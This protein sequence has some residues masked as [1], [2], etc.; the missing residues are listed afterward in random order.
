M[1]YEVVQLRWDQY[2]MVTDIP[3]ELLANTRARFYT[4]DNA[5]DMYG[6]RIQSDI[7]CDDLEPEVVEAVKTVEYSYP[8]AT[9]QMFKHRNGKR[10]FMRWI[11][12]R[13]PVVMKVE[14][15]TITAVVRI[16]RR[17]IYPSA[18]YTRELGKSYRK[19]VITRETNL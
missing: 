18:K 14:R 19:I 13:R 15:K 1:T 7:L 6:L 12:R 11:V 17:D 5:R 4:Y 10:W 8:A 16:E 3:S 9:W 2:E